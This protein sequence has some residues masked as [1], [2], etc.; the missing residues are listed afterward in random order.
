MTVGTHCIERAPHIG[1]GGRRH[2]LEAL[3]PAL[4]R[5]FLDHLADDLHDE[6]RLRRDVVLPASASRRSAP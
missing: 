5:A 1:L 2:A 4:D 6:Q 3:W